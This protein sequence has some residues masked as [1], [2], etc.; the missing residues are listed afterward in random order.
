MES[1]RLS[2]G[3]WNQFRPFGSGFHVLL[4]AAPFRTQRRNPLRGRDVRTSRFDYAAHSGTGCRWVVFHRG[5][6]QRDDTCEAFVSIDD[7][8]PPDLYIAH[9]LNNVVDAIVLIL[10]VPSHR[11]ADA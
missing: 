7:R 9:I 2:R 1:S 11:V 10:D 5:V 8:Q 3:A 6:S 4:A